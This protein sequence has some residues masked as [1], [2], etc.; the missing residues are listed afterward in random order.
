MALDLDGDGDGDADGEER[1]WG[2]EPPKRA[3]QVLA[4]EGAEISATERLRRAP[5]AKEDLGTLV[6]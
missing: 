5:A 3:E 1:G 4:K 2:M 6:A